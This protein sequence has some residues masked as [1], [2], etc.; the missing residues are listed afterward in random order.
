MSPKTT[1]KIE[2]ILFLRKMESLEFFATLFIA[3]II[4]GGLVC[5]KNREIAMESAAFALYFFDE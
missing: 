5:L 3:F 2:T 4:C 1:M